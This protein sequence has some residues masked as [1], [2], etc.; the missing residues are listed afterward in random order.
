MK[1]IIS[2]VFFCMFCVYYVDA[3]TS[4][5]SQKNVQIIEVG[6]PIATPVQSSNTATLVSGARNSV[7]REVP[8]ENQ[9]E[10]TPIKSEIIST[11]RKP[12]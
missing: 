9:Q 11:E 1:R 3:Q 2:I 5:S 8:V 6:Q 12:K 10:T 7:I 4:T